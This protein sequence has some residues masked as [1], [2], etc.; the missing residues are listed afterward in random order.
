MLRR[1]FD[2]V[3]LLLVLGGMTAIQNLPLNIRPFGNHVNAGL[4]R[5]QDQAQKCEIERLLT[6]IKAREEAVV[7]KQCVL[8]ERLSRIKLPVLQ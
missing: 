4:I 7:A 8:R 5:Y 2:F 1:N 6:R 3:A